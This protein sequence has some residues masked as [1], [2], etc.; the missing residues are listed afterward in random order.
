MKKVLFPLL[1]VSI[2][3]SSCHKSDS[4]YDAALAKSYINKDCTMQYTPVTGCD[5]KIYGNECMANQNGI[6]VR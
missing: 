2:L 1:C 6:R 3:A 5:G 4:C